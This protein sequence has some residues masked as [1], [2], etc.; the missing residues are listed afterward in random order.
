MTQLAH[1]L[2][3]LVRIKPLTAKLQLSPYQ[4]HQIPTQQTRE[5]GGHNKRN[6]TLPAKYAD[7][8]VNIPGRRV[9]NTN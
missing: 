1:I 2:P 6:T 8:V 9:G 4:D 3:H 5:R 7:F